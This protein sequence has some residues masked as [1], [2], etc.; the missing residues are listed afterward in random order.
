MSNT[1]PIKTGG[2]LRCS[3]RLTGDTHKTY[4]AIGKYMLSDGGHLKFPIN[5]K[6]QT[7]IIRVLLGS[8]NKIFIQIK[9]APVKLCL[10]NVVILNFLF[11][12]DINFIMFQ[13]FQRKYKC[14]KLMMNNSS[15]RSKTTKDHE[16]LL[17]KIE[18][19]HK[20]F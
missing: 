18:L 6:L 12:Y 3:G 10:E 17:G 7:M 20:H 4:V 8:I 15:I 19:Y 2:G 14:R 13:C 16:V 5:I 9:L 1:N 11:F